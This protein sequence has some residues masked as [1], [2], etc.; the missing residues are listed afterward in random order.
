MAAAPPLLALLDDREH[1][2]RNSDGFAALSSLVDGRV[3]VLDR[4]LLDLPLDDEAALAPLRSVRYVLAVRERTPFG[5]AALARLPSL[6]L[7][8]QTGGHAY[9]V[10]TAAF[11]AAGVAVALG[12]RARRVLAAVPELTLLL[13]LACMRRLGEAA[14]AMTPGVGWPSLV[15]RT[16]SGKRLGLLGM[17]R[18]GRGVARLAT[19]F[20]MEVVA[21]DR[22]GDEAVAA[23]A[24]IPSPSVAAAAATS[25]E[26]GVPRLPLDVLLATSD[27]VSIH[28][29][30]SP[31]S[32]GLLT[33]ARLASMK[34]RSVLI[35]TA[36]GAIVDEAALA[37]A[38]E[39]G[40]LAAAGL[41]VFVDE[42]LAADSPLRSA[43]NAVLTPHV[44]WTTE[45][46]RCGA[47]GGSVV[48]CANVVFSVTKLRLACVPK[49]RAYNAGL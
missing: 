17:G 27:V 41:D 10:D 13:A 11:R 12:R 45:E 6:E 9:H 43:R 29:R 32:T 19:A 21:W 18:H 40:P 1:L 42:P 14:H 4:Q 22:V 28:L 20:G 25:A 35:N 7:L 16:L 2:L 47:D 8:L 49:R 30:L 3:V 46:V 23:A 38:L 36:R 26:D 31:A 33:E 48:G 24:G 34:P 5:A 15:G 37:R 39:H 44:G